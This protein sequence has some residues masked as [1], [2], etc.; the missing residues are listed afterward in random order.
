MSVFS[1]WDLGN[2]AEVSGTVDS[3]AVCVCGGGGGG[4]GSKCQC[5]CV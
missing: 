1:G 5:V 3:R 4:G 2:L